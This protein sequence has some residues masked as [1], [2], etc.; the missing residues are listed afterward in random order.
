M[1]WYP[2]VDRTRID[3]MEKVILESGIKRVQQFEL[4]LT[5]DTEER[6]MTSSGMLVVNPPYTLKS[7]MDELLPRLASQLSDSGVWRSRE[8]A[9]E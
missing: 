8:L 3:D 1:I 5:P 2:V 6:G 9:G 4:G 7:E